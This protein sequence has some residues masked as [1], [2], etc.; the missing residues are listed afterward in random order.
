ML[1]FHS[2]TTVYYI[3]GIGIISYTAF[4]LRRGIPRTLEVRRRRI[5]DGKRMVAVFTVY[6]LLQIVYFNVVIRYAQALVRCDRIN[7]RLHYP[8]AS[9]VVRSADGAPP[10]AGG[11]SF[12]D[13]PCRTAASRTRTLGA[14]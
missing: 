4:A 8:L 6:L 2:W 10:L 12:G 13:S 3:S 7:R 11:R 1:V 14:R 5:D 9:K